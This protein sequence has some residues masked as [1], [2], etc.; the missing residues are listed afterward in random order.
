MPS[1]SKVSW[2]QL[3]VGV[4]ALVALAILFVLVILLTGN[5]SLFSKEITVYTFLED[6]AAITEGSAV[7]LNGILV[8]KISKVGL[9]GENSP[10]RII[11]LD[12]A[13]D[14]DNSG[15]SGGFAGVDWCREPVGN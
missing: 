7:R 14:Q 2:A 8:G 15:D 9:S 5:K 4:M 3:R 10:K 1:A 11:Q 6:S 13:I 12:L